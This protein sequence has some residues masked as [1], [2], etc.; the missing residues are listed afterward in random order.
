MF[1]R[2]ALHPLFAKTYKCPG[3]ADIRS[4]MIAS[5]RHALQCY[6]LSLQNQ[7]LYCVLN[8]LQRKFNERQT[9]RRL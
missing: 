2:M 5:V 9:K 3:P 6:A 8:A 7:Q 4:C 1:T